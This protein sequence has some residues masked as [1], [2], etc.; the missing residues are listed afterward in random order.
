M[1]CCNRKNC[2]VPVASDSADLGP[3]AAIKVEE[4]LTR[5]S[6]SMALFSNRSCGA[7]RPSIFRARCTPN[8]SQHPSLSNPAFP[9]DHCCGVFFL[10][11]FLPQIPAWSLP[12]PLPSTLLLPSRLSRPSPSPLPLP[13][14]LLPHTPTHPPGRRRTTGLHRK[15]HC[16]KEK[17]P[18]MSLISRH[19]SRLRRV[20]M[21]VICNG[22]S[23]SSRRR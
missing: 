8:L 2:G 3:R 6:A 9:L 1:S 10:L 18:N 7:Q 12:S 15:R 4:Q 13:P 22:N 20:A 23:S 16:C 5:Q 21:I 11:L 17:E 14:P 19:S